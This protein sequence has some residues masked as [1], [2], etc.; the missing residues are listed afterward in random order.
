LTKCR[1]RKIDIDNEIKICWRKKKKRK[2]GFALFD[3]SSEEMIKPG[4]SNC[5][6]GKY[7]YVKR[8]GENKN[9]RERET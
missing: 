8:F 5:V 3:E 9:T 4:V 7:T 2:K 6:V 1:K